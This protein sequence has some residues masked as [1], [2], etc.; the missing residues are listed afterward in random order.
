MLF[1]RDRQGMGG[2]KAG[3][4]I[5]VIGGCSVS[6]SDGS[7]LPV[8]S[9]KGRAILGLLAVSPG[10]ML[11]RDKVADLFW[12]D[13]DS[14]R[15][16]SSLRQILK[17]LRDELGDRSSILLSDR[18]LAG[19]DRGRVTCDHAALILALD[20]G[21]F[22]N[23]LFLHDCL[24]DQLFAGLDDLD[25][26]FGVWL[27]VFREQTRRRLVERL[28]AG[29][30]GDDAQS[31]AAALYR[32]DPT[33][34]PALRLLMLH[35]A[36]VG[37]RHEATRLFETFKRRLKDDYDAA[38]EK[39][40]VRLHQTLGADAPAMQGE[41]AQPTGAPLA[42]LGFAESGGGTRVRT[43]A[44]GLLSALSR[45]KSFILVRGSDSGSLS[46]AD[47]V[48]TLSFAG[49][50]GNSGAVV[51][52]R[53]STGALIWS[54]E[55]GAAETDEPDWRDALIRGICGAINVYISED[56]IRRLRL[57]GRS[58]HTLTEKWLR[59]RQLLE[60]WQPEADA[61]AERLFL[62]AIGEAPDHA[63]LHAA[64]ADIYNVRHI[65]FPGVRRELALERKAMLLARRAV[66][67]DPLE[68]GAHITLGWSLAMA[69]KPE[70]AAHSFL[71]GHELNNADPALAMSAAHGLAIAGKLET[72]ARL[73][74]AAFD[75]HPS[76]PW[77]FWGFDGNIRFLCGDFAGAL[78]SVDQSG[79]IK[80]NFLGWK[81]AAAGM[82]GLA[83]AKATADEFLQRTAENWKGKGAPTAEAVTGWFLHI[84]P[85]GREAERALLKEGL[86]RA[87]L[88]VDW[89]HQRQ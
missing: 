30:A 46:G 6:G 41:P 72:A 76:P 57:K 7:L 17:I 51:L 55:F 75:A 53:Q 52:V 63:P 29:M 83:E 15:S 27:A 74:R 10:M 18:E 64:L 80:S 43:L 20:R 25:E 8:K 81:C 56:Q 48:A 5:S 82:A 62:E 35:E 66:A 4:H 9:R 40:T 67:L 54:R 32:L 16:K 1:G 47:Y 50:D 71:R 61:E 34:E 22:G 49:P 19:L 88:P 45:F 3:V 28:E 21:D 89:I 59:G 60:Q 69:G 42:V 68:P 31:A 14:E 58:G 70:P 44:E 13:S 2:I 36:R 26:N 23:P 11:T 33:H 12:G 86:R 38:P 87:G 77:L 65:V 78:R 79:E 84:F 85:F 39:E 73:S 24:A 37:S